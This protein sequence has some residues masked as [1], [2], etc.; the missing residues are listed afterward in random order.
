MTMRRE[1]P[2]KAFAIRYDG[3]VYAYIN[4]CA[5]K[6]SELD[7]IAGEFFDMEGLYLICA[8]HGATYEPDTGR[9]IAGPCVGASLI[10]VAVEEHDGNVYVINEVI[11]SE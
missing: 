5:H 9:C 2:A 6:P 7:W 10:S 3:R 1:M 11:E 4:N 8:T